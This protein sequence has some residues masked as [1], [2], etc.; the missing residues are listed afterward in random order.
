MPDGRR[1]ADK[2][3]SMSNRSRKNRSSRSRGSEP[4]QRQL[5]VGEAIRHTLAQAF[6]RG[7][8]YDP[9]LAGVSITVT[10]VRVSP[11]LTNAV[12]F[13]TPLGGGQHTRE[14]VRA[15]GRAAPV[16]RAAIAREVPLRVV[17]RLSF[18][19]DTSFEHAQ[20]IQ[21]LLRDPAVSRDLDDEPDGGN[22][23]HG[24]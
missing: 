18:Q 1:L 8:F 17:P 5:R 20:R 14:I 3:A 2:V 10:E 9:D 6:Q 12:A 16:L 13:V 21:A 22:D 11:D 4:S 24:T 19:A 15:L 7:E 23:S